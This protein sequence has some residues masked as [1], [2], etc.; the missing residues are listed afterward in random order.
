MNEKQD[1]ARKTTKTL[2]SFD[3]QKA[4]EAIGAMYLG[5]VIHVDDQIAIHAANLSAQYHLPKW[6]T[7]LF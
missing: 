7:V 3:E 4:I 2:Q 5:K 1:S 6:P